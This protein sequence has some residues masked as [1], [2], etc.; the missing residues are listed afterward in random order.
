MDS[1]RKH[2]RDALR[3]SGVPND[4]VQIEKGGK[5]PYLIV[6]GF[7]IIFAESPKNPHY[8]SLNLARDIVKAMKGVAP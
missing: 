1:M 8:C 6:N 4:R 2:L 7:R 5:H 3:I